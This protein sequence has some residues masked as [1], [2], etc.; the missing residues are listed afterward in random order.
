MTINL[1]CVSNYRQ[2]FK[3]FFQWMYLN[4]VYLCL[5][6]DNLSQKINGKLGGINS[7]INL[8]SALSHSS[9]EDLFMF[10]G[11]DVSININLY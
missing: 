1:K 3:D 11:A 6:M 10:F 5:D 8:K 7:V 9:N 2:G 4:Y